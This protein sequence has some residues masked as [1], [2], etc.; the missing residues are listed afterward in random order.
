MNLVRD[1]NLDKGFKVN[2]TYQFA[3]AGDNFI[4]AA[5]LYVALWAPC[6]PAGRHKVSAH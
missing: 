3:D 1:I 4:E 2:V 6:L 5:T